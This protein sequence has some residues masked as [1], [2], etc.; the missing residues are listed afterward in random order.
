MK[1][2]RKQNCWKVKIPRVEGGITYEEDG[3]RLATEVCMG[4]GMGAREHGPGLTLKARPR[5]TEAPLS[6]QSVSGEERANLHS[7]PVGFTQSI[8]GCIAGTEKWRPV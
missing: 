2:E 5:S 8:C 1:E 3:K 4:L 7:S 6:E